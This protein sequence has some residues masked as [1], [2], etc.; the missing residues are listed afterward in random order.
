MKTFLYI[1]L[2][3]ILCSAAYRLGSSRTAS[4]Y[5][6]IMYTYQV[7]I[8]SNS[9]VRVYKYGVYLGKGTIPIDSIIANHK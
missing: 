3:C 1:L 2:A 6:N 5:K 9:I 8:D 7:D 4:R